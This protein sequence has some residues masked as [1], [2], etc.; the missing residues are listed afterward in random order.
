VAAGSTIITVKKDGIAETTKLTVINEPVTS[1]ASIQLTLENKEISATMPKGTTGNLIATA[2]MTDGTTF[3]A[4]PWVTF[5]S[6]NE[7]AVKTHIGGFIEAADEGITN[8][9]ASFG[10]TTSNTVTVEVTSAELTGINILSDKTSAPANS[11]IQLTVIGE[12][13]N[14]ET[15]PLTRYSGTSYLSSDTSVATVDKN[16]LITTNS[17]GDTVITVTT[18]VNNIKKTD[19]ISINVSAEI[20]KSITITKAT[21]FSSLANDEFIEGTTIQAKA[22]GHYSDGTQ[23]DITKDVI[24]LTDTNDTIS[25]DQNGLVKGLLAGPA[26]L[27]AYNNRILGTIEGTVAKATPQELVIDG[28]KTSPVGENIQL[29]ATIILSNGKPLPVTNDAL[30]SSD[31]PNIKV[32]DG[33]V[34]SPEKKQSAVITAKFEGVSASYQIHFTAAEPV[35]LEIQESYCE[36][37]NCPVVTDKT[38]DIYM[39][40]DVNY[41][42][43]SDEAYYPTAWLVYSDGSKRYVNTSAFWWSDNQDA[44]YVNF[45]KGSFVF[46]RD[47]AENVKITARYAGFSA[48]FYVNVKPKADAPTLNS[49]ELRYGSGNGPDI[50]DKTVNLAQRDKFWL[51]AWGHWSNGNVT[52][53]NSKV[54]YSSSDITKAW[55]FDPIS[56]YVHARKDATGDAVITATWQGKTASTTVHVIPE[57]QIGDAQ[58]AKNAASLNGVLY[59]VALP[60]FNALRTLGNVIPSV[61]D[62]NQGTEVV[63]CDPNDDTRGT[64]TITRTTGKVVINYGTGTC[65]AYNAESVTKRALQE[66]GMTFLEESN[67][68]PMIGFTIPDD[69]NISGG[70]Y[71]VLTEG[72]ITCTKA[73]TADSTTLSMTLK[74]HKSELHNHPSGNNDVW[75]HD[76]T[77]AL[78]DKDN[79]ITLS[80][81]G[82]SEGI[83]YEGEVD[84]PV[85]VQSHEIYYANNF[86]M[87]LD[88]QRDPIFDVLKA[89]GEVG[90]SLKESIWFPENAGKAYTIGFDNYTY[91]LNGD[92]ANTEV[93]VD[94]VIASNCMGGAVYYETSQTLIDK[95]SNRDDNLSRIPESGQINLSSVENGSGVITDTKAFMQFNSSN[96]R[97]GITV[98]GSEDTYNTWRDITTTSECSILQEFMDRAFN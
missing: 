94:G 80:G 19:T 73:T 36:N 32:I 8:M 67:G 42:P 20:L 71:Y 23:K 40:Y 57:E 88:L 59:P 10:N 74:N 75:T 82:N 7:T 66:C 12:F 51:E 2:V 96:P 46:G 87:E 53:I 9:I 55:I 65:K 27:G 81:D 45:L 84:A 49:I 33:V 24:W 25:V 44:A 68:I 79:K 63:A 50:T 56:S 83:L 41:N 70:S 26:K 14:N 11:T 15:I 16:G 47:L 60:V 62:A 6:S 39:V 18:V 17:V 21:K 95:R 34:Y 48:N 98:N 72:V 28:P 77:I 4:N 97:I 43:V 30:W 91:S 1:L 54:F 31:N 76:M 93:K 13:T 64:Y 35:G 69:A 85:Q 29:E 92:N 3:N 38:V 5:K 89:N 58:T 86:A 61:N 37:G 52:N 90:Y 78:Q 22:M